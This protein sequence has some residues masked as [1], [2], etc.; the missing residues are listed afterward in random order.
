MNYALTF[1]RAELNRE[2]TY[3][4]GYYN[5]VKAGAEIEGSTPGKVE[6]KEGR[7]PSLKKAIEQLRLIQK[8]KYYWLTPEKN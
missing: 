5:R 1:L 4:R 3:V 2:R 7:I 8:P 6:M